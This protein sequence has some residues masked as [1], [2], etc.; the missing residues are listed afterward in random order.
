MGVGESTTGALQR[1]GLLALLALF[2]RTRNEEEYQ[3][4]SSGKVLILSGGDG[5]LL[6]ALLLCAIAQRLPRAGYVSLD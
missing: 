3:R 6:P 5:W 2:G 1:N 4:F